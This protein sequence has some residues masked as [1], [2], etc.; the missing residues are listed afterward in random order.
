VQ[1]GLAILFGHSDWADQLSAIAQAVTAIGL[2]IALLAYVDARRGRHSEF[3]ARLSDRWEA[4]ASSQHF[5]DS[6]DSPE[7][8]MAEMEKL[9]KLKDEKY[10]LAIHE[11]NFFEDL[12]ILFQRRA[13]SRSMIM[14]SLGSDILDRWWIW[15]PTIL[16]MREQEKVRTHVPGGQPDVLYCEFDWLARWVARRVDRPGPP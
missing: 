13:V 5:V 10:E 6:F 16:M 14:K 1:A 8:F 2:I 7:L 12:S 3:S 11:P 4:L 15:R 9:V